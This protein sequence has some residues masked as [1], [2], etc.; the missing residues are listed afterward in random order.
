LR[1]PLTSGSGLCFQMA[2]ITTRWL[3]GSSPC[4][5]AS[6]LLPMCAEQLPACS[7]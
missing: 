3:S 2:L 7:V 5:E 1:G 6:H 4:G